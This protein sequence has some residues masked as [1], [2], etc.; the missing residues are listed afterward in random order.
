M[1]AL[2]I[3]FDVRTGK[4]SGSINPKDPGLFCYGWQNLDVTPQIEIRLIKDNRDLSQYRGVAGVQVLENRE[5]IN[6]AV[7]QHMPIKYS[8]DNEALFREHLHQR[9]INLD[10]ISGDTEAVLKNLKSKQIKGIRET[11]P[12]KL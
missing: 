3:E 11:K 10:E 1:K 8:I 7:D 4:R 12:Y 5:E 6:K 9:K 2:L